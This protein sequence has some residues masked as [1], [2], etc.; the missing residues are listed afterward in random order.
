MKYLAGGAHDSK[1]KLG[2]LAPEHHVLH[3]VEK[4]VNIEERKETQVLKVIF[5]G[6]VRKPVVD[7]FVLEYVACFEP[8]NTGHTFVKPIQLVAVEIGGG[9]LE[10]YL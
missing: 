8:L 1:D 3:R 6:K 2:E 9:N 10:K 7:P 5:L 4:Q